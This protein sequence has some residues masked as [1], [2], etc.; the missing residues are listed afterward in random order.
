MTRHLRGPPGDL[1]V[2]Q[3]DVDRYG[4]VSARREAGSIMRGAT[5]TAVTDT[6]VGSNAKLRPVPAP[7]SRTDPRARGER[8]T[9]A[10]RQTGP[11]HRRGEQS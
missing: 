4:A 8:T 9:S 5:S 3:A 6:P 2:G 10:L 11:F 7:T 1:H